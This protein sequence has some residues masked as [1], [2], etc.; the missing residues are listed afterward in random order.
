MITTSTEPH[1]ARHAAP[2]R[3]PFPKMRAARKL[4]PPA[5]AVLTDTERAERA[6]AENTEL[7][8]AITEMRQQDHALT[9]RALDIDTVERE[10]DLLAIRVE[11][12][13]DRV[14]QLVAANR[15]LTA[16]NTALR[17]QVVNRDTSHPDDQATHPIDVRQLPAALA[18]SARVITLH[19]AHAAHQPTRFPTGEETTLTIPIP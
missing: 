15:H 9:L 1:R 18:A 19:Q 17:A 16:T 7:R 14:E 4:I 12:L 3:L 8:Q 13:T 2:A 6:E 10:R 5:E 11:R